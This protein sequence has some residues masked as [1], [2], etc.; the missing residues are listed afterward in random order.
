MQIALTSLHQETPE[1]FSSELILTMVGR[2][3]QGEY[4]VWSL[5]GTMCESQKGSYDV[6]A[7][8][9]PGCLPL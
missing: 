8:D 9:P 3:A 2:P 4:T 6:K 5:N 1:G 7:Q